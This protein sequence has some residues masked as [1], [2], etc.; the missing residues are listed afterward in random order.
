MPIKSSFRWKEKVFVVNEILETK[1]SL[2]PHIKGSFF[3]HLFLMLLKEPCILK[4]LFKKKKSFRSQTV[5]LTNESTRQLRENSIFHSFRGLIGK[6][7][8]CEDHDWRRESPG[9]WFGY[10][11][12]LHRAVLIYSS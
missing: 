6:T 5:R 3:Y 4:G 11:P 8:T 7:P 2:F 12:E 9:P 1:C 10:N